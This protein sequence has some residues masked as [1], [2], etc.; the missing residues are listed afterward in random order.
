[1]KIN[2]ETTFLDARLH[3]ESIQQLFLPSSKL[4]YSYCRW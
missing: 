3:H 2:N 4:G 1:M